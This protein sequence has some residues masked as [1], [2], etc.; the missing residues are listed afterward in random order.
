ML[1]VHPVFQIICHNLIDKYSRDFWLNIVLLIYYCIK[2]CITWK[3]IQW[4][5]GSNG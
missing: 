5:K 2:W 1:F 4:K 3:R